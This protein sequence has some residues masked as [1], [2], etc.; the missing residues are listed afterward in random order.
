MF[1]LN[2]G[3]H[4]YVSFEENINPCPQSKIADKLL[5]KLQELMIICREIL[6]YAQKLWK[7]AHYKSVNP[8]S[9]AP[10]EKMWL[11]SK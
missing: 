10:S 3:Y 2:C 8:K 4:P 1:K 7:Q 11:N 9:Y 6:H 5:A